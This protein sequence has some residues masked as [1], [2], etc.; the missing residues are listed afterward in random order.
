MARDVSCRIT[1]HREGTQTVHLVPTSEAVWFNHNT[2]AKYSRDA[3]TVNDGCNLIL[4]RSD[5]HSIFEARQF[6]IVP[7]LSHAE[8]PVFVVHVLLGDA[9][10]EIV[11]LYHDV[12]LQPLTEIAIEFLFARFAWTIIRSA[13]NF[14]GGGLPRALRVRDGA[15]YKTQIFSALKCMEL[16]KHVRKN[17]SEEAQSSD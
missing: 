17:E 10:S 4:L 16:G 3:G 15:M 12:P 8:K 1:A 11:Q 5:L 6:A 14:L 13:H 2:M 7:K 9:Q